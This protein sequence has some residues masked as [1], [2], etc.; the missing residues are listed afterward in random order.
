[1]TS[2]ECYEKSKEAME[3]HREK[4]KE[5]AY[6]KYNLENKVC[7]NCNNKISYEGRRNNFCS[8]SC[9]AIFNNKKFPKR[10]TNKKKFC[11]CGKVKDINAKV[12]FDCIIQQ[13]HLSSLERKKSDVVLNSS[14]SRAKF[15]QIRKM[16]RKILAKSKIEKKCKICFFDIHVEVC[17][18]KPIAS[19]PDDALMKE[20][21]G[22]ENLVYLCPNHHSMLDKGL[23]KI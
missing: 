13:K 22:L 7:K 10:K 16:A 9:S 20:I 1:M 2:K 19:F 4:Q 23:I 15:N 8:R 12:C 14:A 5:L 3:A 6:T 17:H 21:N 11:S 18:I